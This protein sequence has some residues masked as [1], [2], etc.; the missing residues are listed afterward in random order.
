MKRFCSK[1]GAEIGDVKFCTE[2]GAPVEQINTVNA[3]KQ[4]VENENKI[5]YYILMI[6][7]VAYIILI[8]CSWF[9]ISIPYLGDSDL[10]IYDLIG[11]FNDLFEYVDGGFVKF[12]A[13][14][15]SIV[16]M[17]LAVL[18]VY[19]SIRTCIKALKN[20]GDAM[21]SASAAS[22][23]AI[24]TA[25][26]A[27]IAVWILKAVLKSALSSELGSFGSMLGSAV[28]DII[29]FTMAP[30]FLIVAAVIGKIVSNQ[31]TY[32]I[33]KSERKGNDILSK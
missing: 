11:G 16:L 7:P 20:E 30:V 8:L 25:A 10:H 15:F 6:F 4:K 22:I 32:I 23:L 33:W 1:C 29:S 19:Y 18:V 13:I 9:R 31:F 17:L 28:G 27:I 21:S 2:C 24:V 26:I 5:R 12:I 3:E 14:A